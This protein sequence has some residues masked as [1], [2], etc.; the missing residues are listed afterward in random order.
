MGGLLPQI[1]S[2]KSTLTTGMHGG[3]STEENAAM[4]VQAKTQE[5]L[6]RKRSNALWPVVGTDLMSQGLTQTIEGEN[7]RL[8]VN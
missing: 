8:W 6:E 2:M 1:T 3:Q 5:H 7:P 4:N